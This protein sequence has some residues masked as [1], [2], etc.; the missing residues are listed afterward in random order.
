VPTLVVI[1]L[2]V[3]VC[4]V[5][6]LSPVRNAGRH[7]VPR[8]YITPHGSRLGAWVVEQRD[9]FARGMLDPDRSLRL[10]ELPGWTWGPRAGRSNAKTTTPGAT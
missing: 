9:R 6:A 3:V 1:D 4:C 5:R 2:Q 7:P 8:S 10:E